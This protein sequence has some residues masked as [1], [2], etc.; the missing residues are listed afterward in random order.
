MNDDTLL[1]FELPSVQRKKLTVDFA[2]GHQ[3]S[4]GGLLLLREAE[5]RLGVCRRLAEAMP[6]RRD[7]DRVRHAMFEMVMARVSAIACG[8]EDAIDLDRLRH[9]PLM[10]V[11]VGRCPQ[12]GAPLA[13]QS[14]ISRLENAPS[15]TE[16]GRL[17]AA[18]LDQFGATVKP[19]K[20]EVLDIDDTFCAA[21]GGQQLAFWN[22][23]YDERGFAADAHLSCGERRAGGDD[24][25]RRR[26]PQGQRGAHRHQASDQAHAPSLAEDPDRLARRQPL[27]PGGGDGLGGGERCRTTFLAL[28]AM[29]CSTRLAGRSRSICAFIMPMRAAQSCAPM[30]QLPVSGQAAGTA[31]QGRGTASSARCSRSLERPT[32]PG[33]RYPLR[34]HLAARARRGIFTRMSIAH[35]ARLENLIKLHKAQ[36][37]S[38]RTSCHSRDRQSGPARPAYRRLLADAWRARRDPADNPLAKCEFATIRERSSRSA[39]ASSSIS[40]ASA[41]ICRRAARRARCS[42]PSPSASCRPA[43]RP[44]GR[45]PRRAADMA[46][47]PRTRS[48]TS[49]LHRSRGT[50]RRRASAR[51]TCKKA[52]GDA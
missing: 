36:L 49:C 24:P 21:H 10:K 27:W 23:H 29:P 20:V 37:A 26:H 50:E 8:Y 34:R 6:D 12:T 45:V 15:R 28:P 7:P 18:L 51:L 43:H 39:P 11:A 17:S 30:C 14:T 47:Q 22:A 5:R 25:A 52:S 46:D 44:R 41:F 38:D 9:D 13:S 3:S 31:A 4:D 48:I 19:G 40:P 33:A 2:G 35:A 42:A 16:A 1:P 32:S